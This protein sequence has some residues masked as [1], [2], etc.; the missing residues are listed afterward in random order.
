MH[1][2]GTHAGTKFKTLAKPTPRVWTHADSSRYLLPPAATAI[3]VSCEIKM[4]VG[5]SPQPRVWTHA[6]FA[7]QKRE[8]HLRH[9]HNIEALQIHKWGRLAAAKAD[10]NEST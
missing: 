10:T 5:R 7:V 1:A 2:P 9:R 6:D 8:I 4:H 3:A